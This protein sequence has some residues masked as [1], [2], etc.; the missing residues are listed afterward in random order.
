VILPFSRNVVG[1]MDYTPVMFTDNVYR[2]LTTYC[3]ELALPVIFESGWLHFAGGVKEYLDLPEA[4][5]DFLKAVPTA[6][7][8][9]KFLAGEPGEYVVLARRS[10]KTWYVAGINGQDA[11]RDVNVPLSFLDDAH[12]TVT[13]IA[14]GKTPREFETESE[15]VTAQDHLEV[16]LLPYGGFTAV[17]TPTR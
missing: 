5:K 12:Y 15:A 7:D 17:L 14:D 11:G 8:D 2:H 4:P 3:H 1:P 13:L 9:T 10:G 6:W 16:R